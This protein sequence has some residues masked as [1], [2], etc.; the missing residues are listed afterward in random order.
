MKDWLLVFPGHGE[1]LHHM[2]RVETHA[3]RS[4]DADSPDPGDLK[5]A[6]H[7]FAARLDRGRLGELAKDT[8]FDFVLVPLDGAKIVRAS[9]S[10]R[11]A[12]SEIGALGPPLT[13]P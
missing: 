5:A 13:I 1:T 11:Y 12:I 8:D 9:L 6:V 7:S 10:S 2:A 4:G 3:F